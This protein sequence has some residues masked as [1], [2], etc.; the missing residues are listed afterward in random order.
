M[1]CCKLQYW[2]SLSLLIIPICHTHDNGYILEFIS[3]QLTHSIGCVCA[4]AFFVLFVGPSHFYI[5]NH[6]VIHF[7][8][9]DYQSSNA[10]ILTK[11]ELYLTDQKKDDYLS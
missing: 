3:L 1:V 8:D 11:L 5:F 10:L 9:I 6:M 2:S 4:R 7:V